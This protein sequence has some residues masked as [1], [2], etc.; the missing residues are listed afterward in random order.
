M[1]RTYTFPRSRRLP[2]GAD[3]SAAM[4]ARVRESRGPI[5]LYAR[6]NGLPHPRLGLSVA[7][8]G[9]AAAGRNLIK[10]RLR[11]AFRL[12]QHDLPIGYDL[13]IVVRPHKPLI[14]AEYQKLLT[15]LMLKLHAHWSQRQ[16][17]GGV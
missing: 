1:T 16:A 2:D 15:S 10:R 8:P 12:H 5:M 11:E 17:N 9:G 3:F 7:R 14:L 6:P 13:V 4:L